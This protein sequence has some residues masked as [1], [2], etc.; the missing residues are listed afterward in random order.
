M[1]LALRVD[2]GIRPSEDPELVVGSEVRQGDGEGA[3]PGSPGGRGGEEEVAD[4]VV[5]GG[6]GWGVYAEPV[7][8]RRGRDL[9]PADCDGVV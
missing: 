2:F 6:V 3:R 9:G 1:V 5:V 7:E 4:E 8:G